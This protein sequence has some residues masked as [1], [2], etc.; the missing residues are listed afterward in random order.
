M[1]GTTL[2]EGNLVALVREVVWHE[3]GHTNSYGKN[4]RLHSS[5]AYD[6]KYLS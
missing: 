2:Q 4:W 1:Q 5:L 6:I 3:I